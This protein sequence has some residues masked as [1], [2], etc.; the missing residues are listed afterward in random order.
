M[1]FTKRDK[2]K[3]LTVNLSSAPNQLKY[4]LVCEALVYKIV[5][6]ALLDRPINESMMQDFREICGD[7][8]APPSPL[9][10]EMI[11]DFDENSYRIQTQN[12]VFLFPEDY[13]DPPTQKAVDGLHDR[14]EFLA[15]KIKGWQRRKERLSFALAI[16][17]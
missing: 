11:K 8:A 3:T 7:D 6:L 17:S 10:I 12:N 1:S 13:F 4:A 15:R 2:L 16:G 14:Q 5:F 9:P